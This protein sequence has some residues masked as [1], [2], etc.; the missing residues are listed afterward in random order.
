ML[1]GRVPTPDHPPSRWRQLFAID[2]RSLALFRIALGVLILAGVALRMRNFH[3]FYTDEGVWPAAVAWAEGYAP[4][5]WS[6]NLLDS[7]LGWQAG[8]AVA[9]AAAGLALL[10]GWRTRIVTVLAWVLVASMHLRDVMVV[11]GGS[12]LLRQYLFWGMWLPLGARWSLD[13]RRRPSPPGEAVLSMASAALLLQ[14]ALVYVAN[15]I[16]KSDPAWRTTGDAV[17]MALSQESYTRPLGRALLAW[18]DLLR[19]LTHATFALEALG[20]WLAFIP[21]RTARWRLLSAALFISFH[22][23]LA[24]TMTL[25]LFP[26]LSITGWLVFLPGALW[27]RF[28]PSSSSTPSSRALGDEEGDSRPAVTCGNRFLQAAP[29][30]NLIVAAC[31]AL[32]VCWNLRPGFPALKRLDP[33]GRLLRFEQR[34]MMFAPKPRQVDTWWVVVGTDAGGI[35]TNLWTG[36]SPVNWRRPPDFD[37]FFPNDT[38]KLYLHNLRSGSAQRPRLFAEWLARRWQAQHPGAAP[39]T[40]LEIYQLEESI[41]RRG[42]EPDNYLI[43]D[44]TAV[45][46][47]AAR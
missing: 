46:P 8:L 30:V 47:P 29:A 4:G 31:F 27:Q 23:G 43:Y 10:L 12:H 15:A 44:S 28:S 38:W 9:E 37:A 18:P 20:P 45:T 5:T 39:F 19:V 3:V 17:F 26:F 25:G 21:W 2:L 22:A 11:S 13:A 35:E 6:L 32:V 42:A 36:E 40:K 24:V 41:Y 1:H 7:S 34:W 16:Y 14:I 33:L